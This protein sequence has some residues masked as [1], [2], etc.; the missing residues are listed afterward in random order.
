MVAATEVKVRDSIPSGKLANYT[1]NMEMF[2]SMIMTMMSAQ[3]SEIVS[4]EQKGKSLNNYSIKEEPLSSVE[5]YK[6]SRIT[7][8]HD[9][10]V[11]NITFGNL[12]NDIYMP[13]S[14]PEQDDS[15]SKGEYER[16]I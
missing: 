6:H 11:R 1:P 8:E 4:P 10:L 5:R 14:D 12:N 3:N 7:K 13:P 15:S 9:S 2:E 16:K